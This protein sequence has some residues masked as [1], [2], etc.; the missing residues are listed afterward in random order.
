ME[1][2]EDWEGKVGERAYKAVELV[3][4]IDDVDALRGIAGHWSRGRPVTI[5]GPRMGKCHE[6]V[7][8]IF[9]PRRIYDGRV[10]RAVFRHGLEC[11]PV[12][13]DGFEGSWLASAACKFEN[14]KGP[15][16]TVL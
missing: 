5:S 2:G 1:D 4:A 13:V 7:D 6:A 3:E 14:W 16:R 10:R 9:L 11:G 12:P 8:D 15:L